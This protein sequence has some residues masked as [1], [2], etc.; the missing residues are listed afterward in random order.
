MQLLLGEVPGRA[1]SIHLSVYLSLC[2]VRPGRSLA[3]AV[4]NHNISMP[5]LSLPLV[6]I[7]T[8]FTE[9]TWRTEV[10]WSHA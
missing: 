3:L 6:G 7:T 5:Q 1:Q 8:D 9:S 4:G 10:T 2:G